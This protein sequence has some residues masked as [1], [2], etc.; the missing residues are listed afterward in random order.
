M[1]TF[2]INIAVF[3]VLFGI[4]Y[5]SA[6]SGGAPGLSKGELS[7]GQAFGGVFIAIVAFSF[8]AT[9]LIDCLST[10]KTKNKIFWGFGLVF[11]SW[12]AAV[13]YFFVVYRRASIMPMAASDQRN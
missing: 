6:I 11:F 13:L 2:L 4:I 9:M 10:R 3:S 7:Q 8:W 12:V 5:I 1:K